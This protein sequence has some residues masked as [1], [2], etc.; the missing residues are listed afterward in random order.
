MGH[1]NAMDVDPLPEL[2]GGGRMSNGN[3]SG[4][5]HWSHFAGFQSGVAN[6]LE[7]LGKIERRGFGE[8][9]GDERSIVDIAFVDKKILASRYR[10]GHLGRCQE[11]DGTRD[12]RAKFESVDR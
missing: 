11:R 4:P 6:A 9:F 3:L 2:R 10:S 8:K 12:V 7:G 5:R 1:L